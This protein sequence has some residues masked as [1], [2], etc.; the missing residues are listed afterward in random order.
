MKKRRKPY[1]VHY[2]VKDRFGNSIKAKVTYNTFKEAQNFALKVMNLETKS[3]GKQARL[4]SWGT[5]K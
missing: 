3:N 2:E 1:Y 5:N 4:I